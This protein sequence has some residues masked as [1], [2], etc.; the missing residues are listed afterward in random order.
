M[1]LVKDFNYNLPEDKIAQTPLENRTA[2]K[3]LVVD[4]TTQTYSDHVFED[5]VGYLRPNDVL[6]FNNTKVIPARL[7][8]KRATGGAVEV[9]LLKNIELERWEVLVKPGRKALPGETIYFGN[10]FSCLIEEKTEFGGRIVKFECKGVF[11]E[12][13]DKYGAVPLPPYIKTELKDFNRYQTVYAKHDGSVAAPTAGLHFTEELLERIR[14]MGV[15]TCFVTLHVGIGTFR[16]VTV[17]NIH[18]H[19]MHSEEY[20]VCQDVADI[21]NEAKKKG[22][23]VIAI[24]T[25]AIRTL[26]SATIDGILQHGSGSTEIFIYPGYEFKVVDA[27]ITN[28]HLPQST[29]LMLVAAYTGKDLMLRA[30]E[31][32]VASDLY[33]F[34]SFGDAMFVYK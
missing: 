12:L 3:L 4:A 23:R 32:A 14:S 28:F 22:G 7:K 27:M 11:N 24:G 19:K 6:V 33:R 21:V 30:Y 18:D 2:S 1:M 16:P 29:L 17:E 5:F 13:L 31:H 34:F 15:K 10:D 8:G 26:E 9:F 20:F 25:T